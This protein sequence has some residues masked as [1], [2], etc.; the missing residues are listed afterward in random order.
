MSEEAFQ[1]YPSPFYT[2]RGITEELIAAISTLIHMNKLEHA[3][4]GTLSTFIVASTSNWKNIGTLMSVVLCG[5]AV[6]WAR[7]F[8][9]GV[10]VGQEGVHCFFW[11]LVNDGS[12]QLS[13]PHFMDGCTK[14]LRCT[15]V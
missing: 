14:K 13:G 7:W 3:I 12:Y 6:S 15:L 8:Y 5:I 4:K 9:P 10:G 1:E 11:W 2:W